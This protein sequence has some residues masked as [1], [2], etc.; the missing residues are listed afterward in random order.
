MSRCP[1]G[2]YDLE[3]DKA[4]KRAQEEEESESGPDPNYIHPPCGTTV[5]IEGAHK[6]HEECWCDEA[7]KV[8]QFER[9]ENS[10]HF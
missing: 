5:Y 6:M 8:V 3:Y 9:I 10:V 7:G 2:Y 4:I 1:M